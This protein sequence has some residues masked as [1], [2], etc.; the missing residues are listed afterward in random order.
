MAELD[1]SQSIDSI[2]A[3]FK[4]DQAYLLPILHEVQH[5]FGYVSGESV[6]RIADYV[7]MTPRSV[8]GDDIL[9]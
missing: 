2:L 6:N 7:G 4:G 8:R 3:K 1:C 5:E 9:R